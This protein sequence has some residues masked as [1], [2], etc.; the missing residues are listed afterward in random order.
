MKIS[1]YQ[2]DS[3]K[4]DQNMDIEKKEETREFR[5]DLTSEF[6]LSRQIKGLEYLLK[7]HKDSFSNVATLEV[8]NKDEVYKMTN[9]IDNSWFNNL[10]ENSVYH[11]NQDGC[12]ST[13]TGDFIV[14]DDNG[15]K[16]VYLYSSKLIRLNSDLSQKIFNTYNISNNDLDKNKTLDR[17]SYINQELKE[18]D[19]WLESS[20]NKFLHIAFNTLQGIIKDE[21]KEKKPSINQLDRNLLSEVVAKRLLVK[22]E[23]EVLSA[24]FSIE[25]IKPVF[26]SEFEKLKYFNKKPLKKPSNS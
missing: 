19:D 16:E 24:D 14:V 20:T 11:G 1:L 18:I 2:F 9:N 12:K 26:D 5:S 4:I 15:E 7:N 6:H 21:L 13:S 3:R 10:P 23:I 8:S 17:D 25:K 22:R